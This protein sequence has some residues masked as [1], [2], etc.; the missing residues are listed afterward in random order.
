MNKLRDYDSQ[1]KDCKLNGYF[2]YNMFKKLH[3]HYGDKIKKK[4]TKVAVN[5]KTKYKKLLDE[6]RNIYLW[7]YLLKNPNLLSISQ[8][9]SLE[10]SKYDY[11]TCSY[12]TDLR[13]DI[14][15]DLYRKHGL[16][17]RGYFRYKNAQQEKVKYDSLEDYKD[18]L[19]INESSVLY[20]ILKERDDQEHT[21]YVSTFNY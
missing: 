2:W 7:N 18:L 11:N 4:S 6:S 21:N 3:T 5:K 16:I 10:Y 20:R 14:I 13:T 17:F 12:N 1:I 19:N 15:G 9:N 8:R